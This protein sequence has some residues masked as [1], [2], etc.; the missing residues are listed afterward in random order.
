[1]MMRMDI[2]SAWMVQNCSQAFL[3]V[4]IDVLGIF[5]TGLYYGGLNRIA[6]I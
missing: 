3:Y 4:L 1:M 5:E 2:K 6:V